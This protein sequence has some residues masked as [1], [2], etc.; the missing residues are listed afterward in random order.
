MGERAAIPKGKAGVFSTR[1]GELKEGGLDKKKRKKKQ[2]GADGEGGAAGSEESGGRPGGGDTKRDSRLKKASKFLGS[3]S[4]RGHRATTV[5]ES[6]AKAAA[7]VPSIPEAGSSESH[8]AAAREKSR[9]TRGTDQVVTP[10]ALPS[11]LNSSTIQNGRKVA[12]SNTSNLGVPE[13]LNTDGSP[14]RSP[15]GSGQANADQMQ[16]WSQLEGAS[17]SDFVGGNKASKGVKAHAALVADLRAPKATL[18]EL[19]NEASMRK[20]TKEK[21][22]DAAKPQ[23]RMSVVEREQE[24]WKA[25]NKK[26]FELIDESTIDKG[27]DGPVMAKALPTAEEMEKMVAAFT[28]KPDRQLHQKFLLQILLGCKQQW[29]RSQPAGFTGQTAT[30]VVDLD[31]PGPGSR[32]I[33]VGDTHGQLQDVL[34]MFAEYGL[35]S[36]TNRYLFN[37]DIADRGD[38]ATEIFALVLGYMLVFPGSVFVNRGN[39]ENEE[40]NERLKKHGGGFVR[41]RPA[42]PPPPRP[43]PAN[44]PLPSHHLA[45]LSLIPHPQHPLTRATPA[46]AVWQAEEVRSK[47]DTGVF[48][49]FVELY[50]RMPLAF[51]IGGKTLV[52][53]GGLSRHRG[54]QMSHLR[55]LAS[56]QQ[57]PEAPQSFED[58]LFFDLMWSD[59]HPDDVDGVHESARGD[60]CILFGMDMTLDFLESNSLQLLVRSHQVPSDGHG[61]EVVHEGKCITIFSASNYGGTCCNTGAVLVWDEGEE[62][63]AHEFTAP[64]FDE[65]RHARAKNGMPKKGGLDQLLATHSSRGKLWEQHVG[66]SAVAPQVARMDGDIVRMLKER[67]CRHKHELQ[68]Y[69]DGVDTTGKGRVSADDWAKGMMAVLHLDIPWHKYRPWLARLEDDGAIDYPLFLQRF[70]IRLKGPYG[71]WQRGV[72][73][74][75]YNSLLAA[76]MQMEE[77]LSYFDKDGDGFVS[78]AEATEALGRAELNLSAAQIEQVVRSLGLADRNGGNIPT[79]DFLGKLMIASEA[80]SVVARSEREKYD[81]AQVTKLLRS[82]QVKKKKKLNQ[83]FTE[84]DSDGNGYV[85]Y[86]EFAACCLAYQAECSADELA[87]EY[88]R[89]DLEEIAEALDLSKQGRIN[90][91][92]FAALLKLDDVAQAQA[93][94]GKGHGS[95]GLADSTLVQ[96]I[97]TTLW[98]NDVLVNKSFRCFDKEATG[99]L[100]PDDFRTA[101]AT[102]NAELARPHTPLTKNQID[103]LVEALPLDDKAKINYNEF[104][105]AF[106]AVDTTHYERTYT[107]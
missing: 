38:Y 88:C 20:S 62:L 2:K 98:A 105:G 85:D 13:G 50:E 12:R 61:Y 33:I 21:A 39:H 97:C 84:W 95:L 64:T 57:C 27:Y 52:V 72:L 11:L 51:I 44:A 19:R 80:T 70:Q 26:W 10:A 75:L 96:H 107:A 30:S 7:A 28:V 87:Y 53:H 86:E 46:L 83:V 23:R 9:E 77:L 17:E 58:Y 76:D 18:E 4:G 100:S 63:C 99:A 35:P 32:L 103:Q 82:I 22:K 78:A 43:A 89:E 42:H 67:I 45:T 24:A 31:E 60:G 29:T 69:F 41:R 14:R 16:I 49:L 106:E 5:P 6:S 48:E 71:S 47:Y 59:P 92:S 37:G 34:W 91:L 3:V 90:Y 40:I 15:R 36:P 68:A 81:L 93:A 104:M 25:E 94:A 65:L 101:L 8:G 1:G 73:R 102:A 79:E 55:R 56:R 66:V 74:T 54:V